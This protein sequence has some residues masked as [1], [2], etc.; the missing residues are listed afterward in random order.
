MLARMRWG[1]LL[2]ALAAAGCEEEL[3]LQQPAQPAVDLDVL[4]TR[5]RT[6]L[7]TTTV[8]YAFVIGQGGQLAR[9]GASGWARMQ[10]DGAIAQS[11]DKRMIVF[12]VS[13]VLTAVA[14]L[15]LLDQRG[16]SVDSPIGPWLPAE[17]NAPQSVQA[18]T[19]R[20]LLHHRSG[21]RSTLAN[22]AQTQSWDGMR[23]SIANG[24]PLPKTY[25]YQNLNFALFQV[26]IPALW[27]GEP[28]GPAAGS[29]LNET[30]ASFWYRWYVLSQLLGPI[31]ISGVDCTFEGRA[32]ATRFYQVGSTVGFDPDDRTLWC[33][34]GGWYLSAR[35]LGV[36]LA[37]LRHTSNLLPLQVRQTM[38]ESLLGYDG[39]SALSGAH[40]TY[41]TK[42][43]SRTIGGT[44]GGLTQIMIFP[45]T[46]VEVAVIANSRSPNEWNLSTLIR[47]AYEA[48]VVQ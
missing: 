45:Q 28:G 23:D 2:L 14:A 3:G 6:A 12:S 33:A 19:F 22:A 18:L 42:G 7:D 10:Q 36:F 11:I 25:T 16:L 39:P 26:L 30:G 8:G 27:A 40:G 38:D 48:A 41:Y 24:T 37:H 17:W 15:K 46:G 29:S 9:S 43:G 21:L 34:S 1:A 5:I 47:T 31:G 32:T 20:E 4:E 35:E 13:K 44:H